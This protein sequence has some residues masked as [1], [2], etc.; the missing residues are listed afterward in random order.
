M[1][2]SPKKPAAANRLT[3]FFRRRRFGFA[4]DKPRQ[5]CRKFAAEFG[6]F[7]FRKIFPH[8]NDDIHRRQIRSCP[9]KRPAH[10][11]SCPRPRNGESSP[12]LG[13]AHAES[14]GN[15]TVGMIAH[16]EPSSEHFASAAERC[17]KISAAT[18]AKIKAQGRASDGKPPSSFA[19][20]G[21]ENRTTMPIG[22][23]RAKTMPPIAANIRGLI[24]ALHW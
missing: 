18:H 12:P 4:L 5:N 7:G 2:K 13:D 11:A 16:G 20:A 24:G 10:G 9:Q 19:A 21:G 3:L 22:A 8:R 1:A 6:R 15:L 23:A 14:G 17:R